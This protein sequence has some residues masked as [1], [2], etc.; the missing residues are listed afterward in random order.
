MT[1]FRTIIRDTVSIL[2]EL[3][4]I[5]QGSP[6]EL[7]APGLHDGCDG[8]CDYTSRTIYLRRMTADDADAPLALDDLT[9]YAMEVRRHELWHAVLH[10]LGL[11]RY[12]DDEDLCT[13][14]ARKFPQI[15]E[16]MASAGA[17]ADDAFEDGYDQGRTEG[18]T[19]GYGVGYTD[20]IRHA[21]DVL[22]DELDDGVDCEAM[23]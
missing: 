3:W 1:G 12:A 20:G 2:G 6:T 15:M 4:Q 14:L 9:A 7:G 10:V 18:I 8:L 22:H 21:I 17:L 19:C 11:E 16:I 13:V 5:L 23:P